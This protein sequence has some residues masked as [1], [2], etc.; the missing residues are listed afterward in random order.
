MTRIRTAE[1]AGFARVEVKAV[2]RRQL[3][4]SI[5]LIGVLAAATALAAFARLEPEARLAKQG[6]S[7]MQ[8]VQVM[9]SRG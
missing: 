2:A 5:G 9:S 6:A 4:M 8:H 3:S 1:T 7:P